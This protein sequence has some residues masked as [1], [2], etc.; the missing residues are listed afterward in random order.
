MRRLIAAAAATLVLT[1]SLTSVAAAQPPFPDLIPLP[2]GFSPEGVAVGAGSSFYV[3]SLADG[4]IYRG[5]LRTG[6]GEILVGPSGG[7]AVGVEVD[8]K[9]RLW[10]AG[11]PTGTGT[12]YDADTG[13]LV[14]AYQFTAPGDS[15]INDVVVTRDAAYFTDSSPQ[16][17]NT[18]QPQLFEVPISRSSGPSASF[19]TLPVNAPSIVFPNLNGIETTPD[20]SALILAHTSAQA[21][22]RYD[23]ATAATTEVDLGGDTLPNGDGLIRRGTTLYVV[24]NFVNQV[25][26]LTLSPDGSAATIARTYTSDGFDIPTT[27][28]LFGGAL[29]AVNARFTTPPGPDVQYD[30][31]RV[32]LHP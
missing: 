31:V 9:G 6:E 20:G 5:D 30:V 24:Q 22:Y 12:V 8:T 1:G 32:D 27:A 14:A 19:N 4:S 7:P 10:V 3:G 13:A 25:A 2:D 29:Y 21:L 26:T 23:L 17:P 16:T 11:G 15:F 18:A 28:G